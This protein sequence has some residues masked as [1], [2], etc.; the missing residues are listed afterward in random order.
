[1]KPAPGEQS[2]SGQADTGSSHCQVRQIRGAFIVRYREQSLSGQTDT[3]SSH[4]YVRQI[5]GSI[6]CQVQGAVIVVSDRYGE[7]SLSGQAD[8]GRS[9]CIACGAE[10]RKDCQLFQGPHIVVRLSRIQSLLRIIISSEVVFVLRWII[11]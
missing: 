4:C 7:Q 5:P 2:L 9:H 11:F 6:H 10:C 8:T 3:W 1:M